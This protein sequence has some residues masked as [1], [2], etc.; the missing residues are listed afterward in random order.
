MHAH[1]LGAA[2]HNRVPSTTL[3]PQSR[4]LATSADKPAHVVRITTLAHAAALA[5][6]LFVE[7]FMID[8]TARGARTRARGS[9]NYYHQQ[10]VLGDQRTIYWPNI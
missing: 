5:L 6:F 2:A 1:M 9:P 3:I 7:H 8:D 10:S 4:K